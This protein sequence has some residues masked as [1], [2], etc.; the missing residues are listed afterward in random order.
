MDNMSINDM[1][2]VGMGDL[3][4]GKAPGQII[5]LGL[6]SCVGITMYDKISKVGG[7]LHA[8]LPNSARVLNNS[9]KAKFV[10][11]GIVE[12]LTALEREGAS[13]NRLEVKL[14]GGA[15]MFT[16]IADTASEVLQ[17]GDNNVKASKEWL[18]KFGLR[19]I[20][21]ET[22]ANFGRTIV[23]DLESGKV[24]ITAVGQE[25]RYI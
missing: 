17:I 15:T 18:A 8:M 12:L 5:T 13:L 21:E 16:N 25:E 14:V 10:D 24:R 20:A 19:I 7:M 2:K 6:G 22:G 23:L 9:N 11:T 3:K 4:V 1:I